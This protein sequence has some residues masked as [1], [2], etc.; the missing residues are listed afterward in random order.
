MA[1][2]LTYPSNF[3]RRTLEVLFLDS[4]LD[5]VPVTETTVTDEGLLLH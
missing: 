2:S 4:E 3:R 5:A 1:A